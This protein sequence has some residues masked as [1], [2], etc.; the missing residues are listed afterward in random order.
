MKSNIV[1]LEDQTPR[2]EGWTRATEQEMREAEQPIKRVSL[3]DMVMADVRQRNDLF[4]RFRTMGVLHIADAQVTSELISFVP[5]TLNEFTKVEIETMA[6]LWEI[7]DL[8]RDLEKELGIE[9]RPLT[10]QE[11][12]ERALRKLSDQ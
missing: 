4:E 2:L 3:A 12:C 7:N 9:P 6:S 1:G 10:T 5:G 8:M 11:I